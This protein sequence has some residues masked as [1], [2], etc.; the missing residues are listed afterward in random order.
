MDP[1]SDDGLSISEIKQKMI[2]TLERRK[3]TSDEA[4]ANLLDRDYEP[5][6]DS[7]HSDD[8]SDEFD[9]LSDQLDNSPDPLDDATLM[10]VELS[11]GKL[12]ISTQFQIHFYCETYIKF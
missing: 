7:D 9:D 8:S 10:T 6:D 4:A 5:S 1:D 12:N 2:Q 11:Q 3:L